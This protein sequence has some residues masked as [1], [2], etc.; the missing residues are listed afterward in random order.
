[1]A[2]VAPA[3][4]NARPAAVK[5]AG[6]TVANAAAPTAV[7]GARPAT[8]GGGRGAVISPAAPK[9]SEAVTVVTANPGLA[10]DEVTSRTPPPDPASEARTIRTPPPNAGSEAVTSVVPPPASWGS[11]TPDT[12]RFD[13]P[14]NPQGPPHA[15]PSGGTNGQLNGRAQGS[16]NGFAG[17]GGPNSPVAEPQ[18]PRQQAPAPWQH[19][20]PVIRVTGDDG[21]ESAVAHT[22]DPTRGV[23]LGLLLVLAAVAG[24]APFGATWIAALGMVAARVI[25]RTNTA[26]LIRRDQRGPRGSD[27][28]MTLLALPW[29]CLTAGAATVVWLILPIMIGISV[30]FIAASITSGA[31]I[32]PGTPG[33]LAA[34]MVALLLTAWFG[35]GGGGVRRGTEKAV[36]FTV[37]GPRARLVTWSLLALVLVSALIVARGDSSPDWGPLTGVDLIHQLAIS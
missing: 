16:A 27:G 9:P 14:Q 18:P 8:N 22:G 12:R 26:L 5:V 21:T 15:D 28:F 24:V 25:D 33:P 30:A 20:D 37:R 1:L 3:R 32:R 34:G 4:N 19:A 10:D 6:P 31:V 7:N 29:R 13:P 11:A 2:A 23:L 35:P 36:G 17:H